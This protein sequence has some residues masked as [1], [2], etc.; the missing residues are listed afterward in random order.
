MMERQVVLIGEDGELVGYS[1][2]AVISDVMQTKDGYTM[3]IEMNPDETA[4][5]LSYFLIEPVDVT[6]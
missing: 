6:P 3:T 2:R 5:A 4:V 1:E